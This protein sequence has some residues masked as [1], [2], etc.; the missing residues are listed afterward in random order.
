MKL[1]K[2]VTLALEHQEPDR[3]SVGDLAADFEIIES[4]LGRPTYYRSKWRDWR[5]S[6]IQLSQH[7]DGRRQVQALC[8]CTGYA[9]GI[10]AISA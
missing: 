5:W 2:R 1:K 6:G 3:V 4:A 8:G 9:T 7:V 10:R